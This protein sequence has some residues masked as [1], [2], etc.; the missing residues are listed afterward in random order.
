MRL[1]G[2]KNENMIKKPLDRRGARDKDTI[3]V[4][5]IALIDVLPIFLENLE[6]ITKEDGRILI[7]TT[8]KDKFHC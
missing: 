6:S 8:D 3:F 7:G 1:G 2:Y 4:F 5:V